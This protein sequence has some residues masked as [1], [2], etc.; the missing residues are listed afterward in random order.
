MTSSPGL[1]S[2]PAVH[3]RDGIIHLEKIPDT[4]TQEQ[5]A[6]LMASL[7]PPRHRPTAAL[8]R[9]PA[10]EPDKEPKEQQQE[11]PEQ[12]PEKTTISIPNTSCISAYFLNIIQTIQIDLN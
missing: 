12:E 9:A 11:P 1:R 7:R 2:P 8:G 5:L 4:L 10:Q 3:R 6:R